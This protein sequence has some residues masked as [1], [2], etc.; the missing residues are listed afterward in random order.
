MDRRTALAG[1]GA[2]LAWP[3]R[4][5]GA[6]EAAP[7]PEG[8][9]GGTGIVGTLTDFGSIVV[10]GLR[11][12]TGLTARVTDAFGRRLV[13][14]LRIGHSLTVEA[15]RGDDGGLRARRIHIT[16]PVV[17]PVEAVSAGGRDGIVGGVGVTLAPAALGRLTL[18][19][20]VAVSGLWQGD[21]VIAGRLDPVE[22]EAG[23]LAGV[24]EVVQGGVARIAGRTVALGG[25]PIP[26]VGTFVTVLGETSSP[27]ITASRI[28]A[29]RFS[30]AAGP[31]QRLSVEGYLQPQRAAPH[32]QVAGLGHSFD[33]AARLD[34]F[35]GHRALFEG[36]YAGTFAVRT[37][38]IVPE[39]LAQRQQLNRRIV[40]GEDV[41][42]QPAR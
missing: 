24:V 11:I 35:A 38:L 15:T 10:N 23:V 39:S 26:A 40:A 21:R 22:A 42:R 17:G 14:D 20:R 9:I 2:A 3:V 25:A 32:Y 18:G 5:G 29:G 33:A 19:Q 7:R 13:R 31:L 28:H 37:G 8:G 36:P 4:P 27:V 12:E 30:G 1:L 34:P 16:H 41:P 6:Q